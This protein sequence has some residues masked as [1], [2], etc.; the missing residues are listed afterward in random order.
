MP[1]F[2]IIGDFSAEYEP[3]IATNGAIAHSLNKLGYTVDCEWVATSDITPQ[4]YSEFQGFWI[5]P[6]SPYSNMDN[7]LAVIKHARENGVP[8]L[9]TCGGFQHMIIDL[10]RN[11]L[12]L[13]DAGHGEYDPQGSRLFITRLACSLAGRELPITLTPGSHTARIY[14]TTQVTERYYCNFGVNPAYVEMIKASPVKIT[15]ADAEGEVRIIEH[16]THPFYIGTLFVPQAQS[17]PEQ[18]HPLVSAFI[19]AVKNNQ[20]QA[21]QTAAARQFDWEL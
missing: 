3:H 6:G 11:L 9:G 16:P 8:L 20:G 17:T 18:P 14:G 4:R 21:R 15:G 5:A 12:C 1:R 2:A 19:E 13:F 10:A 7:V